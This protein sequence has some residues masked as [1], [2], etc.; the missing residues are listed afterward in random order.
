MSRFI[1]I[2]PTWEELLPLLLTIFEQGS[3]KARDEIYGE[4]LRMA[5]AAD[6]AV[7]GQPTTVVKMETED[8]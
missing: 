4:L 6:M 3:P 1:D 5:K 7:T 2:T 8:D